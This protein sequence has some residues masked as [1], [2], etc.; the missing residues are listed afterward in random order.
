MD[1]GRF[2]FEEQIQSSQHELAEQSQRNERFSR[3]VE[4]LG[5]SDGS[6]RLGALY[7]LEGLSRDGF[8]RQTIYDVVSAY[9]RTRG[10][11]V[12]TFTELE[13]SASDEVDTPS[14]EASLEI[15]GVSLE[16]TTSDDYEAALTICLRGPEDVSVD[17]R[18]AIVA[19]RRVQAL[20]KVI[21]AGASLVDCDLEGAVTSCSFAGAQLRGCRFIGARLTDCVLASANLVS[22]HFSAVALVGVTFD[23]TSLQEC[24]FVETEYDS[25]T[26]WPAGGHPDGA[27][28]NPALA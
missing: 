5:H 8:D 25:T 17:L 3:S 2:G 27:T 6:V 4:L 19:S 14:G 26:T 18:G 16:D 11:A 7:A 15:D 1:R 10:P 21:L 12:G 22:C 20:N 28:H 23:S 13:A 24:T 9:A